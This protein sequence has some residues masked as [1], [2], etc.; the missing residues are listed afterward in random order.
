MK[1]Y[2]T[3]EKRVEIG[4]RN[5]TM[6]DDFE[7]A[8]A[9]TTEQ[10]NLFNQY[11][12]RKPTEPKKKIR[13]IFGTLD[14]ENYDFGND[15]NFRYHFFPNFVSFMNARFLGQV[16]FE[17]A[18]F[19]DWAGFQSAQF[20][21][22][23]YFQSVQFLDKTNFENAQFSGWAGF[24]RTQFSDWTNFQSAQFSQKAFFQST[25]FSGQ[26]DF[27]SA[28]FSFPAD[29]QSAQFSKLADFKSAQFS[30]VAD[31]KSAQFSDVADFQSAEFSFLGDFKTTQFLSMADFKAAEFSF[32]ADFQTAQFSKQA[33]FQHTQF[34]SVADFQSAKF[35]SRARFNSVEFAFKADF[36]NAQF[37]ERAN[38]IKATFKRTIDF[39]NAQFKA[40][41]DFTGT[42]FECYVPQFYEATLHQNTIFDNTIWPNSS[43]I[44]DEQ[45]L[46]SNQSAYNCLVLEMN[47]QLRHEQE[48]YF[49]AKEL[50][51]KRHMHWHRREVLTWL[52]NYLYSFTSDYG[53]SIGRP[54]RLIFL[55]F[56]FSLLINILIYW[57]KII[58]ITQI[59]CNGLGHIYTCFSSIKN[60]VEFDALEKI[61]RYTFLD[62]L[63]GGPLLQQR[64]VIALFN[65]VPQ[66]PQPHILLDMVNS[67]ASV[68]ILAGF[69]LLGLGLRNRFRI[70]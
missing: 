21:G 49:F 26:A 8:S 56:L 68:V 27:K 28:K 13:F 17:S 61:T 52:L 9:L 19:S 65:E 20:S 6:K 36:Q 25:Q 31:F 4:E 40:K 33:N 67:F 44:Q 69:F 35:S 16:N 47:K 41:T 66:L 59:N 22:T 12:S 23:A 30:D 3:T 2:I 37:S 42:T 38:F 70:R 14:F 50:E 64:A 29:F 7:S 11:M 54:V 15:V 43:N 45:I 51:A 53:R 32:V 5:P 48:L 60:S 24:Q 39:S 62:F 58:D 18:Q 10:K 34:L 46:S 57:D 55:P 1:D 63:P